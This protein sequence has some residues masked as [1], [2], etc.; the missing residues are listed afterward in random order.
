MIVANAEQPQPNTKD[1]RAKPW[2]QQ[3]F[4]ILSLGRRHAGGVLDALVEVA[5][6]AVPVAHLA[7]VARTATLSRVVGL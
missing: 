7:A 5:V 1:H 4:G 2:H 6:V 3:D